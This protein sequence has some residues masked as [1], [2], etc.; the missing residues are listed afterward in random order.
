MKTIIA[1]IVLVGFIKAFNYTE[2]L[3]NYSESLTLT[4]S[5]TETKRLK[6]IS[7]V[8]EEIFIKLYPNSIDQIYYFVGYGFAP[9]ETK[10]YEKVFGNN[11][12]LRMPISDCK[13]YY[14]VIGTESLHTITSS[15][16]ISIYEPAIGDDKLKPVF[17]HP[18]RISGD[19]KEKG[20]H[21]YYIF[22]LILLYFK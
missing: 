5:K 14:I 2:I 15:T 11:H 7:T 10:G 18:T 1:F 4:L 8:S 6:I 9:N 12:F 19:K 16:V 22:F 20:W 17:C 21:L 13:I 3:L